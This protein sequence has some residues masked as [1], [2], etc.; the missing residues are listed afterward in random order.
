MNKYF[1]RKITRLEIFLLIVTA[2][3]V[4]FSIALVMNQTEQ[5]NFIIR[6]MAHHG[7]ALEKI[8]EYE[9][10]N[11]YYQEQLDDVKRWFKMSNTTKSVKVIGDI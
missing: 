1:T 5:A 10:D 9:P 11:E 2:F 7:E 8:L 4:T 3:A 6:V